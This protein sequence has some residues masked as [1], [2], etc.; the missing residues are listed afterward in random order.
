MCLLLYHVSITHL[1]KTHADDLSACV[2]GTRINFAYERTPQLFIFSYHG[3]QS[4]VFKVFDRVG[5]EA[6]RSLCSYIGVLLVHYAVSDPFQP[7]LESIPF[8]FYIL[9]NLEVTDIM[10]DLKTLARTKAN[11]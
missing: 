7:S 11:K 10:R 9:I 8:I 4:R 6:T 2:S 3:M 5:R 1:Q